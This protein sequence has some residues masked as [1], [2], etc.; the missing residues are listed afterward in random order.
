LNDGG[1]PCYDLLR[2]RYRSFAS[3]FLYGEGIDEFKHASI[4]WRDIWRLGNI[5]EG[6]LFGSNISSLLGDDIDIDFWKEK[7][8]GTTPLRHIFPSLFN[9]S[10]QQDGFISDMGTWENNVWM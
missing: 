2:F 4:W 8:I 5:E 7:W 3:N 10:V 1:T 9:L 6:G